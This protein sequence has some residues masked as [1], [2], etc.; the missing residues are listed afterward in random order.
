VDIV[1]AYSTWLA[2]SDVPKLYIHAQPGFFAPW[3]QDITSTWRNQRQE[4]VPGL[5]FCQE[6]S[7]GLIGQHIAKFLQGDVLGE[8]CV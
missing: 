6:D 4:N 3:I 1:E 7:G 8:P 5:H 2:D